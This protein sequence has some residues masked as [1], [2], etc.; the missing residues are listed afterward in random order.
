MTEIEIRE[1]FFATRDALAMIEARTARVDQLVC[2]LWGRL[3]EVASP[4]LSLPQD[5]A[6]VAI[7]GYGRGELFPCSDID[8]LILTPDEK[9]QDAIR[10]PLGLFLRDLWDSGLRL[11][12]SVHTPKDCNQIEEGNAEL[13]VSL[14]DRRFLVRRQK[15]CSS[16]FE[17]LA[18][19]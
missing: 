15:R 1:R 5:V 3:R 11:S 9:T 10:E 6:L 18:L 16:G 4:K 8:L 19:S 12:Q 2:E 7:G 14:L 17:I 13:A